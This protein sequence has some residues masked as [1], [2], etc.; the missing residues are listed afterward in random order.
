MV[1]SQQDSGESGCVRT[2]VVLLKK[3]VDVH[4]D[5]LLMGPNNLVDVTLSH[6]ITMNMHKVRS[7]V[8]AD[9][10]SHHDASTTKSVN[11]LQI[12]L[13][14]TFTTSTVNKGSSI[15]PTKHKT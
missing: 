8:V 10:T 9:S 15:Q 3:V 14:K 1:I 6:Q 5:G 11:F 4:H 2:S 13:C 12:V 7:G